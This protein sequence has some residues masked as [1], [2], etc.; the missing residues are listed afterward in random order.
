MEFLTAL[1]QDVEISVRPAKRQGEVSV[2]VSGYRWTSSKGGWP[3]LLRIDSCFPFQN[4]GCPV[5][6]FFARAGTMLPVLWALCLAAC[7]APT[8]R[9]TSTLSPARATGDCLCSVRLDP[10]TASSRFW[11]RPANVIAS[12]SKDTS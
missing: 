9:I 10:A 8:A 3:T 4:R 1:E 6:A 2:V 5:L 12:W 11:N 7:I